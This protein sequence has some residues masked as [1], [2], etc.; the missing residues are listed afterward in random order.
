MRVHRGLRIIDGNDPR[1]GFVDIS[2]LRLRQQ[3]VAADYDG[4]I[5]DEG[6]VTDSQEVD[7]DVP[8]DGE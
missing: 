6:E 4:G 8:A 5:G 3:P 7:R 1:R 2:E